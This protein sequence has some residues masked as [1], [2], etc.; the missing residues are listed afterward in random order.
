MKIV[1]DTITIPDHFFVTGERVTYNSAGLS[2]T[3]KIGIALTSFPEIGITTS[4]IPDEGLFVV[5]VD[6]ETIQA[7]SA[8]DALKAVPNTLE[9]TSVG[10]GNSHKFIATNQ[11]PKVLIALDNIIQSPIVSLLYFNNFDPKCSNNR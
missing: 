2:T 11:N 5:K 8:E 10:V 6:D 7:R 1:G 9:F 4:F 3:D